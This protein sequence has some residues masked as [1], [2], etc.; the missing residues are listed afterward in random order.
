MDGAGVARSTQRVQ[1]RLGGGLRGAAR[2]GPA[3]G[4]QARATRARA[5]VALA[6]V[7]GAD[8]LDA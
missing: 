5:H 4:Q 1:S 2:L 6:V 8:L 3:R 7:P